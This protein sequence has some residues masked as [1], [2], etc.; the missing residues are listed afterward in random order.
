MHREAGPDGESDPEIIL[1]DYQPSAWKLGE[2]H[3]QVTDDS[4]LGMSQRD[5]WSFKSE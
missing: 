4:L 1:S 2:Y 5:H 3:R